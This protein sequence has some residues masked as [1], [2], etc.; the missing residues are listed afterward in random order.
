MHRGVVVKQAGL[1]KEQAE[2]SSQ[3]Q[4]GVR[5]TAGQFEG[6]SRD[7]VNENTNQGRSREVRITFNI[8]KN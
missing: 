1:L 5:N 6:R 4:A 3:T 7:R 2:I 8:E